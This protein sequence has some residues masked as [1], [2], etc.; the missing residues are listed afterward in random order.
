MRISL[1]S[2]TF[3][4]L[5]TTLLQA[6]E[7]LITIK[8]NDTW[9][10]SGDSITAQ[11][12]HTNYIEAFY[13]TRYPQLHLHFRNSGIG[14]NKTN[15]ILARFDYDVAAWKPSIVSVE[16]G[17]NDVGSATAEVYVAGM[18]KLAT[19]IRALQAQP[20]LISSSP[21]NDGSMSDLL[22]DHCQK[23]HNF[24]VALQAMGKKENVP[25]IDQFDALVN[26]WGANKITVDAGTLADRINGLKPETA[27]PGIDEL[28]AFSKAWANQ[29]RGVQIGGDAVHVGP[30]GQY[31]M[32]SVILKQLGVDG[33]VSSATIKADGTIVEAKRCK[34]SDVVA[35]DGKIS[36]TRLDECSPW[37]ILPMAAPALKLMPEITELS[38]Y[39]LKV[40][41]LP[42]GKYS[43]SMDGVPVATLTGEDLAKGWN[44]G[45]LTDGPPAV[46]ATKILGLIDQLQNPLNNNW[47]AASKSH[48]EAKLAA[49]QKAIEDCEAQV[50]EAVQ[51]VAIKF[52]IEPAPAVASR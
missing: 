9:V 48:D 16:L 31:C 27:V 32:A 50:Q 17:M 24:T 2:L 44:M 25:V 46:R 29:P 18:Q 42:S 39:M 38:R 22:S 33:E 52:T 28:K 23:L 21:V 12:L 13:R 49:A 8:D 4:I 5:S 19:Q 41:G 10:M 36:F 15:D 26:V 30:V 3:V 37:P 11:R 14:G 47:R 40:P 7:P 45:A 34:I 6:A 51:P 20:L 1:C 35:K 43:V